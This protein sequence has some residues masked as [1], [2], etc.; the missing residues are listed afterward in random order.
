MFH[1]KMFEFLSVKKKYFY[2]K[3]KKTV[4][5]PDPD[6]SIYEKLSKTLYYN[7]ENNYEKKNSKNIGEKLLIVYSI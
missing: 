4:F 2:S 5:L 1:F 6:Q 7:H 3:S